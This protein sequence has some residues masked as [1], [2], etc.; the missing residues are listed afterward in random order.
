M[1][2]TFA[3]ALALQLGSAGGGDLLLNVG[4]PAPPF[5]MR[6][7][8]RKMFSLRDHVGSAPTEARKAMVVVFF[9]TW[10]KPCMK[11]IPILKSV[12]RRWQGKGVEIVYVGLSQGEKD[13]APFAKQEALPWRVIPDS[14]G[15][16]ARRYG[17]SQLPH[18]FIVDAGGNIAFQH[19]GIADNLKELLDQQL[20][21]LTGASPSADEEASPAVVDRPRFDTT[22]TIARVP[23]SSAV[24]ARWQPL[25]AF[26]GEALQANVSVHTEPSYEA[27]AEALA[28]GKYDFANAGPM[29]CHEQ[30]AL[31]EPLVRLER[32]G[33][34]TYLGVIFALRRSALA[35]LTG[36]R[37]KTLGLVSSE[38]T[39]GGLYP[40]LALLDAGLIPGK[41]VTLRW[42]G[43]HTKVAEAVRDGAVD[44]GACY[45][46]CLD[47]LWPTDG[48]KAA[49]TRLLAYTPEIPS[50]AIVAKRS[51]DPK[52]KEAMRKALVAATREAGILG[53]ISEGE[54][55]ITAV[56]PASD[57]DLEQ[58]GR[59][60]A[61]LREAT[62]K[63]R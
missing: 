7:L 32:Q 49:A 56:V 33:T 60:M 48:D 6:D 59:A 42:L 40:Q 23:S 28:K 36:L 35:N 38:S 15:L 39:S 26:V 10:C 13:L 21:R 8:D 20:A 62:T 12:R 54:K 41:D 44:A 29:L 57:A 17:V 50:E 52:V 27:F 47:P 45:E 4:D 31:Y 55:T 58:V 51:L 9:A 46:G 53:Q 24:V 2:V 61:R 19:R 43:N 37:G 25:A 11:E 14:F 34:P 63:G 16:L 18:L 30:R 1:H 5:S 3:L 22:Y